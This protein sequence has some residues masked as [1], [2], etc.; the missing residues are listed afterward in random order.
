MASL[1]LGTVGSSLLGPL[2]GFIGSAI[3]AA[4]D[5][6]LFAPTSPEP[7]RLDDLVITAAEPGSPIPLVY[8]AE[9]VAAIPIHVS[10]IKEKK[11]K[12]P[13]TDQEIIEYWIDVDWLLCEGPI[14]G[15]GRIWA[16]GNYFRSFRADTKFNSLEDML[17]VGAWSS[18]FSEAEPFTVQ[19]DWIPHETSPF[20]YYRQDV[21][22]ED[23]DL[24]DD[25]DGIGVVSN[26]DYFASTNF[27]KSFGLEGFYEPGYIYNNYDY[28]FFDGIFYPMVHSEFRAANWPFYWEMTFDPWVVDRVVNPGMP[29]EFTY[30]KTRRMPIP[31]SIEYKPGGSLPDPYG[32]ELYYAP[33][34]AVPGTN[35]EFFQGRL[36]NVPSVGPIQFS[37]PTVIT[38]TNPGYPDSTE[39]AGYSTNVP[40]NPDYVRANNPDYQYKDL[41]TGLTQESLFNLKL[42]SH[43]LGDSYT[44]LARGNMVAAIRDI[45]VNHSTVEVPSSLTPFGLLEPG[46][47]TVTYTTKGAGPQPTGS[48]QTNINSPLIWKNDNTFQTGAHGIVRKPL[49]NAI[50]ST[51]NIL[52]DVRDPDMYGGMNTNDPVIKKEMINAAFEQ[53]AVYFVIAPSLMMRN[54]IGSSRPWG[55]GLFIYAEYTTERVTSLDE[56][57]RPAPEFGIWTEMLELNLSTFAPPAN[58]F[59]GEASFACFVLPPDCQFVRYRSSV[60]FPQIPADVWPTEQVYAYA[61]ANMDIIIGNPTLFRGNTVDR[62]NNLYTALNDFGPRSM[63]NIEAEMDDIKLY[64]GVSLEAGGQPPDPTM[65]AIAGKPIPA[66]QGRAHLVMKNLRLKDFGNKLP[67]LTVEVV[68]AQNDNL[69]DVIEDLTERAGVSSD[70]LDLDDIPYWSDALTRPEAVYEDQVNSRTADTEAKRLDSLVPGYGIMRRTTIRAALEVLCDAFRLDVAEMGDKLV[71][72]PKNRAGPDHT[73]DYSE[74]N[75]REAGDAPQSRITRVTRDPLEVPRLI[76][77]LFHDIEREYQNNSARW[78]RTQAEGSHSSTVELPVVMY[79]YVAKAWARSKL[80]EIWANRTTVSFSLPPKYSYISPTDVLRIVTDKQVGVN[81]SGFPVYFS[82]DTKVTTLTRGKDGTLQVE[83]VITTSSVYDADYG[84]TLGWENNYV[85]K[86]H[87]DTVPFT[88][89]QFHEP[90]TTLRGLLAERKAGFYVGLCDDNS[91]DWPGAILY[92]DTSANFV[93]P[94]YGK[95]R[96]FNTPAAIGLVVAGALEP[97][98]MIAEGKSEIVVRLYSDIAFLSSITDEDLFNKENMAVIGGEVV[99]FKEAELVGPRLYRLYGGWLRGLGGS[100]VTEHILGEGFMLINDAILHSNVPV[101][102]PYPDDVVVQNEWDNYP[103]RRW[104]LPTTSGQYLSIARPVRMHMRGDLIRPMPPVLTYA[105]HYLATGDVEVRWARQ[106]LV[107]TAWIDNVDLASSFPGS[108]MRIRVYING[109]LSDSATP[110]ATDGVFVFVAL[111]SP[112]DVVTTVDLAE[113]TVDYPINAGAGD[114]IEAEIITVTP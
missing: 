64:R 68:R 95:A 40:E 12:D 75:A 19:P 27:V 45:Y 33:S 108:T 70:L 71:F 55:S 88:K 112:G 76:E 1:V 35:I 15:I 28:S 87:R 63:L 10:Q 17:K 73:I 7:P 67:L 60:G 79:P 29:D 47:C 59:Y 46:T 14:L 104:Y 114:L 105:Y 23:G 90:R 58:D 69:R 13:K 81:D 8:G 89:A 25:F 11:L 86:A 16:D 62:Y 109:I 44:E 83:G 39:M 110:D 53:A 101:G 3:G 111:V 80:Q 5:A 50:D 52:I 72:R 94:A 74:L 85:S 38:P 43:L 92:K 37:P 34:Y 22:D 66:Y 91:N 42:E 9:R 93:D 4:I 77:V 49:V 48:F 56:V 2:G 113:V 103:I 31:E 107:Y 24:V 54:L 99:C 57:E 51:F 78:M 6:K 97:A 84:E 41:L 21:P 96:P 32:S 26:D 30:Y 102:V 100:I 61:Y 65:S 98:G 82:I 20:L 36:L 106:D 18:Y